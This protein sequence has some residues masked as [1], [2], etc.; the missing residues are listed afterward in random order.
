M[1]KKIYALGRIGK[2]ETQTTFY[3]Y[4]EHKEDAEKELREIAKTYCPEVVR[5]NK[6][7]DLLALNDFWS[8]TE[9][10]LY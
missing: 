8:I 10:P 4:F 9:F 5:W 1:T 2:E 6:S 3:K 7:G